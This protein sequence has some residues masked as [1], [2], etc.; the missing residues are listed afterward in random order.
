MNQ[1][2]NILLLPPSHILVYGNDTIPFNT[3]SAD[4]GYLLSP[5]SLL[6]SDP[7]NLTVW[8]YLEGELGPQHIALRDVIP[9]TF[10]YL[11]I[12]VSGL[13]GNIAVCIVIVRHQ[14]MHTA[15]NYYL[16]NL[17]ISDL[18]LLTFG[19]PNDLS[20][21]WHQY[22]WML[23][24]GFC[25]LRALISEM[26]S[27]V[28][29]LT[30]VSFSTE[31][32]LSICYPLYLYTMSGL[33]RAVRIIAVL[34]LVA[35]SAALPFSLY[36][37]IHYICDVNRTD[38]PESAYCGMLSAPA[39][40][41]EFSFL[42]FFIIPMLMIAVQYT[43]MAQK[44]SRRTIS[45]SLGRCVVGNGSSESSSGC[46]DLLLHLLGPIPLA[47][48]PLQLRAGKPVLRLRIPHNRRSLLSLFHSQ[49]HPV[50]CNVNEVQDRI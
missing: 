16:F 4:P 48:T 44:I 46:G 43:M 12:F 49:P 3:S 40:L 5:D 23:G 7:D 24:K 22:P 21:Y 35:F 27:Y 26:S 32:Y 37:D 2:R 42:V 11:L 6:A 20:T 1:C 25:K 38:I 50:Q 9:L 17:A 18:M 8:E 45:H 28:S 29:V 19:L 15:T 36:T 33:Q 47:K 41:A 39:G 13:L 14:T 30:I 34:W 10:L 31:R